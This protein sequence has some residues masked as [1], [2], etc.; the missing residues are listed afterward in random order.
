[1]GSCAYS[2]AATLS[3]APG[4][5]IVEAGTEAGPERGEG[6]TA[7]LAALAADRGVPFYSIDVDPEATERARNIEGARILPG[8]AEE[9]LAGWGGPLIKF[10]WLDGYDWPYSW[11][12]G[13]AW[14]T[15]QQAQYAA[16]GDNVTE[17]ASMA[18]H[19]AIAG[20]IDPLTRPGAM[21]VFD[22]TWRD[23]NRWRG[24]GGT[25]VPWLLGTEEWHLSGCIDGIEP[26]DGYACLEKI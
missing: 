13:E 1:M 2:R 10:A 17:E 23:G 18:S 3:Y 5:C 14:F 16:R 22:D 8:R 25:A 11:C 19:L 6:S 21:V 24:K 26:R 12:A 7:Y 4:E 20:K 15:A 9:N